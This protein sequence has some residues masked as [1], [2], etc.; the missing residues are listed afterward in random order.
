MCDASPTG[1]VELTIAEIRVGA[2]SKDKNLHERWW[3]NLV[4]DPD[5]TSHVGVLENGMVCEPSPTEG[6]VAC[7]AFR[8]RR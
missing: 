7:V 8:V 2:D 4:M 3:W 6:P 5:N 1:S